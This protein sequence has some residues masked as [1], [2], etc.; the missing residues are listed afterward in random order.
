MAAA[1]PQSQRQKK[2]LKMLKNA[3]SRSVLCWCQNL[4][5]LNDQSIELASKIRHVDPQRGSASAFFLAREVPEGI[6]DSF[7]IT[8]SNNLQPKKWLMLIDSWNKKFSQRRKWRLDMDWV[9]GCMEVG[10]AC[11]SG[12]WTD[13]P[14]YWSDRMSAGRRRSVR[15][16]AIYKSSIGLWPTLPRQVNTTS[17]DSSSISSFSCHPVFSSPSQFPTAMGDIPIPHPSSVPPQAMWENPCVYFK[18]NEK[19]P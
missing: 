19:V 6:I 5:A 13:D 7:Q 12:I 15:T 3:A 10:G 18:I 8:K 17:E 4:L 16:P 9:C 14:L 1:F 2:G 11:T